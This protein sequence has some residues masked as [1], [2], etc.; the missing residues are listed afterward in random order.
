MKK[1]NDE[2]TLKGLLEIFLPKLWIVALVAILCAGVLGVYTYTRPNTYTSDITIIVKADTEGVPTNAAIDGMQSLASD[3][4][5]ILSTRT[6]RDS[7]LERLEGYDD[8]TSDNVGSMMGI[9]GIDETSA[10]SMS[11][12]STDK[13]LAYAL[14]ST[15]ADCAPEHIADV[16]PYSVKVTVVEEPRVALTANGKGT[17]RNTIIG[18][19]GGLIVSLL[20][21]FVMARLDVVIHDRKKIEDAFDIPVLGVIPRISASNGTSGSSSSGAHH[22][23]SSSKK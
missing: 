4:R 9:A 18:F 5:V 2:I 23:Q 13:Y 11:V 20:A 6:F 17:V 10:F 16:Y 19:A 14:A 3:Y 7:V 1:Q 12:T 21:I 22:S 15:M 8:L